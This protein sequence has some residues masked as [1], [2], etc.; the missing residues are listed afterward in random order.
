[1][2]KSTYNRGFQM[3]FENGI[4]ISVQYGEGNYCERRAFTTD[5]NADMESPCTESKNAEVAIWKDF[6]EDW[7]TK[8]AYMECFNEE[9]FDDV[10]GYQTP[11]QV[12][13]LIAWCVKQ[14]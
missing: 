10:E 9:L 2:F 5:I 1:M 8:Q 14:P 4:T 6:S 3:T 7:I 13:T 12:A 11:E